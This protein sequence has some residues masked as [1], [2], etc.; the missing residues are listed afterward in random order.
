VKRGYSIAAISL[1]LALQICSL[2]INAQI[3]P[4]KT[5]SILSVNSSMN[6]SYINN[7]PSMNIRFYALKV[8][9]NEGSPLSQA[10][11]AM[12]NSSGSV[13]G[14]EATDSNGYVIL[15]L[16]PSTSRN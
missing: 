11:V 13:I 9:N 8:I 12:L 1:L 6:S 2:N 5:E 14:G 4:L 10:T 3:D 15:K 16:K 7:K